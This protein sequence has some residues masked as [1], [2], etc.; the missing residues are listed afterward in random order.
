MYVSVFAVKINQLF[1]IYFDFNFDYGLRNCGMRISQPP[2]RHNVF[3]FCIM[4]F[5]K[6]KQRELEHGLLWVSFLVGF[7]DEV[8]RQQAKN[9][10]KN[11]HITLGLTSDIDA[12]SKQQKSF[13]SPLVTCTVCV[14]VSF[15][16]K[17]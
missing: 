12:V 2:K 7:C 11:A 15:L 14:L 1:F 17:V 5:V 8:F 16:L 10:R 3:I 9:D 6:E 13:L 4:F